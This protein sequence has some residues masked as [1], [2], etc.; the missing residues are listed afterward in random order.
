VNRQCA[1]LLGLLAAFATVLPGCAFFFPADS[2]FVEIPEAPSAPGAYGQSTVYGGML[3][4]AGVYPS[5]RS[6]GAI[7][8]GDIGA[9][10]NRIFDTIEA[11]LTRAGCSMKD[12]VKLNVYL[13]DF[14]DQ[15]KMNEVMAARLGG[16]TPLRFTL[17]AMKLPGPARLEVDLVARIPGQ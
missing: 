16:N 11:I 3:F 5:E 9:Q 2:R 8:R 4:T 6:T 17:P 15:A 14:A 10:T 12:V 1:C 13:V 7:M